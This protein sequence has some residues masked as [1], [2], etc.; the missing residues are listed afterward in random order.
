MNSRILVPIDFSANS[1]NAYVYANN[2]ADKMNAE[3]QLVTVVSDS[4]DLE[5]NDL[6]INASL[7]KL[8]SFSR[9]HPNHIK[10]RIHPVLTTYEVLVG[11]PLEALLNH[12][13]QGDFTTI[14]CG[15]RSEHDF[16][17]KWLGTVSSGL[18]GGATAPVLL[19][20][21][22][23]EY[24]TPSKIV[25]ATDAHAKDEVILAEIKSFKDHF[26][27][28]LHFIHV[29]QDENE[30]FEI[31]QREILETLVAYENR[32]VNVEMASVVGDDIAKEIFNYAESTNANLLIMISER[33]NFLQQIVS[34]STTKKVVLEA[35]MPTMVLHF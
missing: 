2:M 30:E 19:V 18:A 34:K 33:R 15:T 28:E 27:S 24:R 9:F 1:F 3:I 32:P 12:V 4:I 21:S 16:Y 22:S 11:D 14:V 17:E 7:T 13:G 31:V 10:D 5:N 35:K 6:K 26:D 8:K 29:L 25:V 20:P 23:A